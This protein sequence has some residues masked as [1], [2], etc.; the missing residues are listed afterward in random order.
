[1]RKR[2]TGQPTPPAFGG[3]ARVDRPAIL[4]G[5]DHGQGV[6][7]AVNRYPTATN[8][9]GSASPPLAGPRS[10]RS[11]TDGNKACKNRSLSGFHHR[12]VNDDKNPV[13]CQ[14]WLK[15][16][17]GWFKRSFRLLIRE[18]S[19]SLCNDPFNNKALVSGVGSYAGGDQPQ[20]DSTGIASVSH[21]RESMH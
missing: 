4:A 13:D 6:D 21:R 5:S 15:A 12:C 16:D 3:K 17:H 8:G 20:P 9:S 10:T 14:R 1:M 2:S 11:S 7:Q 18:R 19:F